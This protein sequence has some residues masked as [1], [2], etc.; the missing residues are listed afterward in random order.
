[1][2]LAHISDTHIRNYKYQKEY[3]QVFSRLYKTLKEENDDFISP[4]FVEL[5]SEFLSGLADIA[6]TY[7]LL[8]N[9]DGNLKN[10]ARQDALTPIVQNLTL[11][12]S[13]GRSSDARTETHEQK[14]MNENPMIRY[15]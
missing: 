9:H 3:R 5:A 12:G 13:R 6:P 8:G 14:Q 11:S 15:K 1:M 7:V 2:R 4:E 10:S